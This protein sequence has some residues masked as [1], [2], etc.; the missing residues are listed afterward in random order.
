[1]SLL[2]FVFVWSSGEPQQRLVDET[3]LEPSGSSSEDDSE[4]TQSESELDPTTLGR[5]KAQLKKKPL[6][7]KKTSDEE[8]SPFEPDQP[9]KQVKKRKAVQAGVIP[10]NVRAKKSGAEPH[11]DKGGKKEKHIQ[12]TQGVEVPKEP[13]VESIKEPVAERETG[14]D[15]Y[16][17]VTG[18]K[19]ASPRPPPQDKPESSQQKEKV[20]YMFEGFPEA[21]GI[22]TE[23]IPEEDYDMFNDQAVKEL[24]QKV[25][26]LEKEKAKIELECDILKK[27]VD[28]LMKAH[29]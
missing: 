22:Y 15:D 17:E 21:T 16:V 5:G 13:E 11:K 1:M 28:N 23:D 26:K 29:N 3:V 25:N 12:K 18:F 6:K 2:M 19:A 8:D 27:Q 14:G 9:K 20:D 7:K 4:A 10:R 24:V